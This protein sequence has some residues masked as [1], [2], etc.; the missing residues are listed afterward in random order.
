MA[1]VGIT[2][3]VKGDVRKFE[4]WCNGREEVYIVQVGPACPSARRRGRAGLSGGGRC[5]EA[6]VALYLPEAVQGLPK[7]DPGESTG[8][9]QLGCVKGMP[10]DTGSGGVTSLGRVI[11]VTGLSWSFQPLRA[12]EGRGC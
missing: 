3:S 8:N 7:P 1:A 12:G 10:G 6:P 5:L 4:I 2:E 9:P 11:H